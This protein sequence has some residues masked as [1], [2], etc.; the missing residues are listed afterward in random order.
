MKRNGHVSDL[1]CCD[2]EEWASAKPLV[3]F[4]M[5]HV[6]Y[7]FTVD[8]P[9]IVLTVYQCC[10]WL[11]RTGKLTSAMCAADLLERSEKMSAEIVCTVAKLLTIS[12]STWVF[13]D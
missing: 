3:C 5:L 12:V 2:G 9:Q 13:H 11:L 10:V 1:L 6:P 8:D 4:Y 7:I